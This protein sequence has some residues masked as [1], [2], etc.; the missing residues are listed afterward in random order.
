MTAAPPPVRLENWGASSHLPV[1]AR[2][3]QVALAARAFAVSW[4]ALLF[5]P[6]EVLWHVMQDGRLG[7]TA[8]SR[9]IRPEADVYALGLSAWCLL[10]GGRDLPF[11]AGTM[12]H[13][14]RAHAGIVACHA[15][16]QLQRGFADH[17]LWRLLPR[18]LRTALAAAMEPRP[19]MRATAGQLAS[20]GFTREALQ[21]EQ[22]MKRGPLCRYGA[23]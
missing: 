23:N 4:H 21:G 20:C 19:A 9:A 5:L 13:A 16:T 3:P 7:L 10:L 15:L 12:P 18:E 1:D 2:G 6:P 11:D 22:M 17:P 14:L 8:V